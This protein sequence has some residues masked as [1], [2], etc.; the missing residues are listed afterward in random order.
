MSPSSTA[1][2]RAQNWLR[3]FQLEP[4]SGLS[5][6][7]L[8][9]DAQKCELICRS[10]DTG[11]VVFMN[12]VVHDGTRCSYRDPYS[13]CARGECVVGDPRWTTHSTCPFCS[14]QRQALPHCPHPH[15]L[16]FKHNR[17]MRERGYCLAPVL[18]SCPCHMQAYGRALSRNGFSYVWGLGM[19]E[20]GA[21]LRVVN[22]TWEPP[23][24]D[25]TS[26][27]SPSGVIKKWGP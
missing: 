21:D 17:G 2:P 19:R 24:T 27:L 11:D 16:V 13:V 10:E 3:S 14:L 6:A 22:G 12:Q 7:P 26:G 20:W 8:P 25:P 1:P 9:T 23:P 4:S 5:M 15:P 18:R